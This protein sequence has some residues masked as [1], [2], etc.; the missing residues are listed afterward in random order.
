[1]AQAKQAYEDA[2]GTRSDTQKA[3]NDLLQRKHL[4]SPNDVIRFTDLYRSEHANEQAELKSKQE[5]K[6]AEA[7]VEEKSRRLMTIIMERYHEEQVWSDKI[8]AAS[9]YG[10]WGLIGMNIMAFLIVQGF[11]EPRRRRKQVE[12]Y[13]ELVQDLTERGILPEKTATLPSGGASHAAIAQANDS[14]D[15]EDG[16]EIAPVAVGGA[17][18]GGEDV[19]IRMIQSAERQE[20]RLDRME[21]LLRQQIPE[22]LENNESEKS[23]NAEKEET[24]EA[25]EFIVA[26]DGTILFA[27]NEKDAGLVDMGESWGEELMR[28]SI[29]EGKSGSIVIHPG[30]RFSRVLKDGD[31]EV[32][33]TRRDF[34]LSGLGGAIIGGLVT[35]AVMMNR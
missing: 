8:R 10:T 32:V 14:T 29:S 28:G 7:N 4:W 33:A 34:L 25:G 13:E 19:L 21:H 5:Y 35:L 23:V 27:A 20:E 24:E 22:A 12:R 16:R 1:M 2:I 30:S 11:V 26:E 9:T 17:L 3:I 31:L 15:I 6:Q 18:L